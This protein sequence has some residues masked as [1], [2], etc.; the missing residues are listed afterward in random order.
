VVAAG[1]VVAAASL[2]GTAAHAAGVPCVVPGFDDRCETWATIYDDPTI[3]QGSHQ[4]EP[5]I[6]ASHDGKRVF[7]SAIDE[8]LNSNDPYH[9]P[10]SWVVLG[11]DGVSGQQLWSNTY[12]AE[13]HYDRPNA[14]TV[15]PDGNTVYATG[16]SYNANVL[17]ATDRDLVTIAYN[18][19]TGQQLW[20]VR[21]VDPL[22]HDAG[23]DVITS[24][25]GSQVYVVVNIAKDGGEIDWAA[26]AYRATDGLQLWRTTYTGVAPGNVNSP[27]GVA[28]SPGGDLVY[29]TGESGGTA[30]F[31]SDYATVAYATGG[32][33]P[34]KQVWESRYDGVGQQFPDRA[35]GI[36]V[37][38]DGRVI[39]TGDSISNFSTSVADD[40]ATVAYDGVTGRQLW[41]SR[42]SG[43]AGGIQFGMAVATSPMSHV[44]VVTGQSQPAPGSQTTN[45]ATL[46]YD[47]VTGQQLWVQRLATPGYA[48]EFP[49]AAA[50]TPDG[51]TAVVTGYDGGRAATPLTPPI[52]GG[53]AVTV[54]YSAAGGAQQWVA[55]YSANQ[56]DDNTPRALSISD[57]GSIFMTEQVAHNQ[58]DINN[59]NNKY[60]VATLAYL[61]NAPSTA[62][63]EGHS[64]LV[65]I[66]AGSMLGAVFA[67]RRRRSRT[68]ARVS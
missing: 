15:S 51:L 48:T 5:R 12:Q 53:D 67:V 23:T 54:A 4:L 18:A 60:D 30:Q 27:H 59:T 26:V 42:Y 2:F 63:P 19:T 6:A 46:G 9:S 31:D 68:S 37:D 40:Y 22:V 20:R 62:V 47:T 32:T 43:P 49:T 58:P 34:G 24:R 29:I 41:A 11:Y 66:A 57:N 21:N 61:T 38:P 1:A 45:W 52:A 13:G 55:R 65:V 10:A 33:Q 35:A 36:A 44:A 64:W 7:V 56:L 28:M 3:P 25:D 8:A 39:V 17:V 14:I 16:A 50:I